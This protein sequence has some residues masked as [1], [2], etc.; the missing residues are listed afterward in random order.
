MG[1]AD[2]LPEVV[3]NQL[4]VHSH[5]VALQSSV[6]DATVAVAAFQCPE[7]LLDQGSARRDQVI[8]PLESGNVG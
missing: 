4:E 3:G 2:V 5:G 7:D 1:Q 8:P 6:P